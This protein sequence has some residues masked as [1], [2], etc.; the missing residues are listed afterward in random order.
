MQT[1]DDKSLSSGDAVGLYFGTR[2]KA[3]RIGAGM[4]QAQLQERL[5]AG[6]GITLDTSGITR[7]EAGQREPRL[8]EA[9][10][11]AA[12]LG[13]GLNDLTPT[14]PDLDFY[15]SGVVELMH[16][17]RETL[18]KLLRSVDRV[19]AFIQRNPGCSGDVDPDGIFQKEFEWFK[20]RVKEEPVVR[21]DEQ[22][23]KFSV[24][25]DKADEKLKR[26]LLQVIT[27]DLVVTQKLLNA[28]TD[29]DRPLDIS[30]A[31]LVTE[32]Q[33]LAEQ[34]EQQFNKLKDYVKKHGHARVPRFYTVDGHPLGRWVVS[35]RNRYVHGTLPPDRAR[36]LEALPGWTWGP[37]TDQWEESFRRLADYAKRNGDARVPQADIVDGFNL[38]RWVVTQRRFHSKGTLDP[39]QE[40]RLAGLPGWT[41]DPRRHE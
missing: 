39:D 26:Q 1:Q 14:A 11:I 23:L 4:T 16:Q 33:L 24:A 31:P 38:G 9:L 22:T 12:I 34:W 19:T 17:S 13:F 40:R 32:H 28:T 35:Q 21:E 2:A 10:A 3:A 27:A 37:R 7:I 36:Q 29:E 15:V 20:Q 30:F 6:F 8:S 25:T 41:W 5:E 18:L